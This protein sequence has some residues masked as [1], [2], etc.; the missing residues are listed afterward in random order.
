MKLE[1]PIKPQTTSGRDIFSLKLKK[2]CT[3][4]SLIFI[5]QYLTFKLICS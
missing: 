1:L 4:K 3:K 5:F 2:V